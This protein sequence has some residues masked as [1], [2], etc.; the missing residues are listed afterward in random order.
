[1]S[2]ENKILSRIRKRRI[3]QKFKMNDNM[4]SLLIIIKFENKKKKIII[5]LKK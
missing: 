1:M 3:E 5:K 4:N 2:N